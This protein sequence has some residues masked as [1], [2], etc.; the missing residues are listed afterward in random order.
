MGPRLREDDSEE[1][2]DVN[3]NTDTAPIDILETLLRQRY[4]C[5]AFL[6]EPVPR[7]TIDRVLMMMAGQLRKAFRASDVVGR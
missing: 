1:D 4:S 6:P 5:R 7:A 3:N 2:D